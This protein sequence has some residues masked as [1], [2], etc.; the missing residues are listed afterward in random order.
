MTRLTYEEKL[1]AVRS[2]TATDRP[3]MHI[4]MLRKTTDT[5][6]YN[7]GSVRNRSRRTAEKR[8]RKNQ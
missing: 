2:L 6:E 8:L 5:P 1:D 3:L 4:A 7:S